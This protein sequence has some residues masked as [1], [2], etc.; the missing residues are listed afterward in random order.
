MKDTLLREET[1]LSA[2]TAMESRV[3]MSLQDR[4]EKIIRSAG[5]YYKRMRHTTETRQNI[6]FCTEFFPQF[7]MYSTAE[8]PQK[9]IT[10]VF[11]P[12]MKA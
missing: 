8:T 2:R 9:S 6:M 11:Y 10:P 12:E 3:A 1:N 7:L 4:E 5:I